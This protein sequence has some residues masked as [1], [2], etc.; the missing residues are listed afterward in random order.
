MPSVP[1]CGPWPDSTELPF[2]PDTTASGCPA[3]AGTLIVA[4]AVP[5]ITVPSG[6]VSESVISCAPEE[7]VLVGT[8]TN[9]PWASA[10][11]VPITAVPL[12]IIMVAP[13]T[14]RPASTVL[15]C[16]STRTTSNTGGTT[17]AAEGAGGAAG[18]GFSSGFALR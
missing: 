13:G 2:G 3:P 5:A 12:L 11:V 16:A 10:V 1:G 18:V 4:V 17:V 6:N 7:S 14:P 15:P 8:S 9:A